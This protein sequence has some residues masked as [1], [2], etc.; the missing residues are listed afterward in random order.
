[1]PQGSPIETLPLFAELDRLLL[2]LLRS[3]TPADWQRPTLARQWTVQDV[4]A[5]LLD[6]NL[7]TLSML[8]DGHFDEAP[9]DPSYPGL[10]AYLNRLNADWVRAAR[11][12]SPVVLVAL[13][14]RRLFPPC[15]CCFCARCWRF[16]CFFCV[17]GCAVQRPA[18]AGPGVAGVSFLALGDSYTIGEGEA[19]AARWLVQLAALA[20]QQDLAVREPTIIARTSWTTAELQIA[21]AE[22]R[23]AAT[24]G[25]VALLIGVNN[26]YRGQGV[27]RY[28]PEFRELLHEAIGFADGRPGRVVVLSVPDWGQSPFG[29]RPGVD[30]AATGA[31]IDRFNAV[32]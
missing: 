20:R 25:L 2:E 17:D 30:P 28:R 19:K 18:P 9:Q 27:V 16:F 5:H 23:P 10:V 12:L 1:M 8:R 14:V 22:A 31:E 24:Y 6:G 11:R 15:L 26:Q 3:L 13:L 4:A 29:Q 7:R 21:I 32:A